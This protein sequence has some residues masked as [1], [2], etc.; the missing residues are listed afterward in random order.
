MRD[1]I[2]EHIATWSKELDDLDPLQEGIIGRI[3]L[4]ARHMTEGRQQALR[5][6]ELVV[7]Q[8][9]TLLMLRKLGSPYTTSPSQLAAMLGLTRGALSIRL[10]T[11]EDLGLVSR[12][13]DTTDR[14]RVQVSLTAAGRTAL[15]SAMNLEDAVEQRMLAVLTDREK[16]TL[17]DLLRKVVV[18]IESTSEGEGR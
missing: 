4:L 2:D 7:W 9:K 14:R 11:L 10:A 15:E 5:S 3:R 16:R 13:H 1:S 12:T 8:L 17:A 6:G 18:G